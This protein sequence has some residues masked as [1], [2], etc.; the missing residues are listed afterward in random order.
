VGSRIT[1]IGQPPFALDQGGKLVSRIGTVFPRHAVLVTLPGVHATQRNAFMDHLRRSRA[2]RGQE[3]LSRQ[4]EEDEWNEAVDLIM[5]PDAI[6]IRP[7]PERMPLAFRADDLLQEI[8]PKE[9]IKFLGLLNER[10]REAI[11]KRGEWWRI[12]PLPKTPEEMEKMITSSR[13]GV[14]G[15]DI[16]YYS[17]ATGTRFLTCRQFAELETLDDEA[18]RSHLREI[19]TLSRRTNAHGHP[20]LAFFPKSASVSGSDFSALDL[21]PME[22][23]TLRRAYHEIREKFQSSVPPQLCS[24]DPHSVEWRNAMVSALVGTEEVIVSEEK[25]LGLSPEF[26]MQ[27]EWLPGGRIEEG[28]LVFDPVLQRPAAEGRVVDEK[29]Q[30]F[31]FNFVR[32]FGDLEFVN[33]GRVIGSLSRRPFLYGRR[34][35][36]IAVLKQRQSREE[37]VSV[38]RMQKQGVR[39][40]LEEGY[41]LLEAM[42]RSEEYTEY[43]LDR[44]LG[45]RQLGMNLP[46]RV[47]SKRISETYLRPD[48]ESFP[49]WTT[50]FE[51]EYIRGVAT[52]KLPPY[53][54]ESNEFAVRAARLLGRA[55]APNIIVG[56]CDLRD[57]PLF[58]DG[59]EV[60]VSDEHGMP[61]DIVVTDHTGTFNDC[62]SPLSDFAAG[63]A[64]PVNKRLAVLPS[65]RAFAEAYLDA[66]LGRFRRIQEDYRRRKRAF[67]SLFTYRPRQKEGS[68]AFRWMQ[69]LARLDST[70]P[71]ELVRLVKNRLAV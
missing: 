71:A 60:L 56:R 8:V 9:R 40:Y 11:K 41:S 29:P 34:G 69:V 31:I 33:I 70:D 43:I 17:S 49:V 53:R 5:D 3:P 48:G 45:C 20:E 61:L 12:M 1:F 7:D 6:L 15:R 47:T 21:P 27:I 55:A 19:Q 13:I 36:Y 10:V 28:E 32:E 4:E 38:I 65:P 26:F 42:M 39:E 54:F 37:I 50:Y 67:D 59:D 2:E 44:R 24:D 51:R 25:L 66:F 16:Y 23:P 30:K 22:G 35:V 57:T 14:S 52:D 58:D 68:F 64:A 46:Q 63:Y 18:L 62:A